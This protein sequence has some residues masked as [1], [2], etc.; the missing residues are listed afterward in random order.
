LKK[1]IC[2]DSIAEI[3]AINVAGVGIFSLNE[4]EKERGLPNIF[5]PLVEIPM[6]C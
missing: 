2:I 5:C 1:G 6:V 4:A 3:P